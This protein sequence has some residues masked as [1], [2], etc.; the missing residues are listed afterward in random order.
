MA[1]RSKS[2]RRLKNYTLVSGCN[3]TG[4]GL[5]LFTLNP[6]GETAEK[7]LS[8]VFANIF[9]TEVTKTTEKSETIFR[10][11]RILSLRTLCPLC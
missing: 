1:L 10:E 4:C 6:E 2:P 7:R 8:V 5:Y 9:T 3:R 11:V